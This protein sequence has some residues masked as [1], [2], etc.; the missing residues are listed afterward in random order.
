[1]PSG[2]SEPALANN[3]LERSQTG[4]KLCPAGLYSTAPAAFNCLDT[5]PA[6]AE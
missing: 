5:A 2:S 4:L 3:L 6:K 1:M